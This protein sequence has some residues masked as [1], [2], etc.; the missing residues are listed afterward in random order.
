MAVERNLLRELGWASL[1]PGELASALLEGLFA[2]VADDGREWT[3]FSDRGE[4]ALWLKFNT[5]GSLYYVRARPEVDIARIK[6]HVEEALIASSGT[7]IGTRVLF[8]D[9]LTLKG[10]WRYRDRFQ[11]LPV[12]ANAPDLKQHIGPHPFLL[13]FRYLGSANSDVNEARM[14]REGR[15]L[16]LLLSAVLNRPIT[17]VTPQPMSSVFPVYPAHW[18]QLPGSMATAYCQESYSIPEFTAGSDDFLTLEETQPAPEL[19]LSLYQAFGVRGN[20]LAVPAN[21]AELLDT[22]FDAAP[23]IRD[24]FLRAAYWVQHAHRVSPISQSAAYMALIGAIE[25]L[26]KKTRKTCP[27]CKQPVFSVGE[28]FREFL[29]EYAPLAPGIDPVVSGAR[30]RLYRTRSDLSH[31]DRLLLIDKDPVSVMPGPLSTQEGEA[32]DHAWESTRVGLVNWLRGGLT[33]SSSGSQPG[34]RVSLS[35]RA[36]AFAKR[37]WARLFC[38]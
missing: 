3:F 5:K 20:Q 37:T 24:Q 18:V 33:T 29:N 1:Q 17:S 36:W 38:S 7:A 2:Y 16:E 13:Q 26:T 15:C 22:F 8:S 23:D 32:L 11:I 21:L 19:N 25:V 9:T 27:T 4:P 12:P 10:H 34:I 31:G 6:G 35:S 14:W 30:A 28:H